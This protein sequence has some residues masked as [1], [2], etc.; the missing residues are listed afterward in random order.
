MS[1]TMLR[2]LRRN[3]RNFNETGFFTTFLLEKIVFMQMFS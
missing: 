2:P 3:C 1:Y